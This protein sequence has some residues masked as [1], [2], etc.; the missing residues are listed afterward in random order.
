MSQ[1]EVLRAKEM[2]TPEET[3][4]KMGRDEGS[5][6]P[7]ESKISAAQTPLTQSAVQTPHQ[8]PAPSPEELSEMERR[9][10]MQEIQQEG[11]KVLQFVGLEHSGLKDLLQKKQKPPPR[12]SLVWGEKVGVIYAEATDPKTKKK[13][14]LNGEVREIATAGCTPP[15]T[16]PRSFC[17]RALAIFRVLSPAR[18][19]HA[20]PASLLPP[21][22]WV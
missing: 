22:P 8:R 4:E 3:P 19:C 14:K 15:F 20:L 6:T 18:L 13:G 1:G 11:Q 2:G 10:K 9:Q 5:P 21:G 16:G 17:L 7:S 12:S